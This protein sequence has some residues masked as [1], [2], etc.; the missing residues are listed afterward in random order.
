MSSSDHPPNTVMNNL[1]QDAEEARSNYTV[2]VTKIDNDQPCLRIETWPDGKSV[3]IF[4]GDVG[5]FSS[6]ILKAAKSIEPSLRVF[7]VSEIRS[8]PQLSA[9]IK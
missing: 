5:Q 3:T 7:D 1:P 9:R 6:A 2:R 8:N 4:G